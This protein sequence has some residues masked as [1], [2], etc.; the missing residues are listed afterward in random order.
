MK[1]KLKKKISKKEKYINIKYKK[2]KNRDRDIL[3][4]NNFRNS[5][6]YVISDSIKFKMFY[7]EFEKINILYV[8]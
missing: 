4:N 3:F 1:E 5:Q 8:L 6:N 2:I 7:E